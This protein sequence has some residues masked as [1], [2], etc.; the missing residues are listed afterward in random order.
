MNQGSDGN[1]LLIK[2]IMKK[3]TAMVKH[4]L[5]N[6]GDIELSNNIGQTALD[7]AMDHGNDDIATLLIDASEA[8]LG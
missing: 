6:G 5:N 8:I 7:I 2:A 3:D 4:L 1:T